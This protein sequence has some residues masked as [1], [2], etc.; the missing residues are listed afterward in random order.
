MD[1]YYIWCGI[2]YAGRKYP[3]QTAIDATFDLV[4]WCGREKMI[5]CLL[6]AGIAAGRTFI[7]TAKHVGY[8]QCN[9]YSKD[10]RICSFG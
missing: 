3:V 5:L 8:P 1:R 7:I 10:G 9:G 2:F 4:K 6:Q